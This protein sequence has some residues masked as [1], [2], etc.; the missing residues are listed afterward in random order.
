MTT[1]AVVNRSRRRRPTG[2][3]CQRSGGCVA[4][5]CARLTSPLGQRGGGAGGHTGRHTGGF[6]GSGAR[7]RFPTALGALKDYA[8]Q[9]QVR[10]RV[11]GARGAALNDSVFQLN[12]GPEEGLAS[13]DTPRLRRL[14]WFHRRHIARQCPAESQRECNVQQSRHVR[15]GYPP[16]CTVSVLGASAW[17]SRS[18]PSNSFARNTRREGANPSR[19]FRKSLRVAN[20]AA[21]PAS[22]SA[23]RSF[24]LW[25]KRE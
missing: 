7:F 4:R 1:P 19:R 11:A 3:L 17:R 6:A 9:L 5:H 10:Q 16:L 21:A 20:S 18:Q 8:L 22:R 24:T 2:A 25:A 14:H 15:L 23:R 13:G 12:A